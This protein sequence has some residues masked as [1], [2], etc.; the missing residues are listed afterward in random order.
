MRRCCSDI[1]FRIF[2]SGILEL[3]ITVSG[4]T[5]M[6]CECVIDQLISSYAQ[7]IGLER[8]EGVN[9]KYE[10][11]CMFVA[12]L[13]HQSLTKNDRQVK[14]TVVEFWQDSLNM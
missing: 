7:T 1:T 4:K 11:F 14:Q 12:V 3:V 9:R 5:A 13:S 10:N 8:V 6:E 2:D